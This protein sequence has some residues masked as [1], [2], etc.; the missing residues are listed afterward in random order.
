MKR[1]TMYNQNQGTKAVAMP[2]TIWM[3][4][5]M[6]SGIRRPILWEIRV[7]NTIFKPKTTIYK[8]FAYSLVGDRSEDNVAQQDA[9]HENQLRHIRPLGF[10]AHQIP[11]RDDGL[12]EHSLIE[13]MGW[14]IGRAL[15]DRSV[16]ALEGCR[17]CCEDN[18]QLLEEGGGRE[19]EIYY[20]KRSR[21]NTTLLST[22]DLQKLLIRKDS[23]C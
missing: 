20:V 17:R 1:I 15:G 9:G 6:T 3:S 8:S 18:A 23:A 10:L 11:C 14:T 21:S 22:R 16:D 19:R 5:A 7:T 13:F 4:T 12:R 2:L